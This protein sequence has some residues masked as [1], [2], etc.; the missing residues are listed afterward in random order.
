L[1][2]DYPAR[3]DV[4]PVADFNVGN[5]SGTNSTEKVYVCPG[6]TINFIN[7]SWAD[8][9]AT[10]E[11]TFIGATA[12]TPTS[13]SLTSV[14]NSFTT[15]GPVDVRLIV[16]GNN[17]S[18]SDTEERQRVAYVAD[19]NNKINPNGYYQEWTDANDNSR[20]PIFNYFNDDHK[21]E[22][23]SV[24]FYD[25]NSIRYKTYDERTGLSANFGSPGGDYDDFFMPPVDLTSMSSGQC[26]LNFAYAGATRTTS[27]NDMNDVFE[28]AYS[29][30]CGDN[31]IN[32]RSMT[33][34][35]LHNNGTRSYNWAPDGNQGSPNWTLTSTTIPQ[36]AR[37]STVLFRFRYRPG[38]LRNGSLY[39]SGNNF[40]IDRMHF[41]NAPAG[42][43]AALIKEEG[44]TL[45]PNPTK[46]GASVVMKGS[47]DG[48]TMTVTDVTGKLVYRSTT[49]QKTTG[50]TSFEIPAQ[51]VSAKGIYFVRVGQGS[52]AHTE[53]LV[54]Y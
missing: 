42:V 52:N 25:N 44:F 14:T 19:V 11:W 3:A 2:N 38:T 10:A 20:Y 1:G 32:L 49:A 47:I 50:Y 51:A 40:Y 26:F 17:G 7:R 30:N 28:I 4:R 43:D 15:P 33:K 8:T 24:G 9:I 41:S 5:F 34:G 37:Q 46:G 22:M 36:S 12:A 16:S 35:E 29:V 21:W 31:W 53:K 54:V 39:G 6:N 13:N 45:A 48:A 18:G 27:V 23:S